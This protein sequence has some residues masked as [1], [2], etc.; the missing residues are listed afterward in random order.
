MVRIRR[1]AIRR[2]LSFTHH[3]E[4]GFS[5]IE[6]VIALAILAAVAVIF[7][8]GMSTS[9]RA[10][11]VSQE[12]VTADSLAKSEMEYVKGLPYDATTIP[13][14]YAV[15]PGLAVPQGYNI[16]VAAARLDPKNGTNNDVGLQQITVTITNNGVTVYTVVGYKEKP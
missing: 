3:G 13:L 8:V 11:L 14:S 7:L 5:L 1:R 2:A 4:T 12:R 15:D 9:S 10:V 16:T 6:V